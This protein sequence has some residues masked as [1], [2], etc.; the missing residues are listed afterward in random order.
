MIYHVV[1]VGGAAH[2]ARHFTNEANPT[3]Q[4]QY[5]EGSSPALGISGPIFLSAA[6]HFGPDVSSLTITCITSF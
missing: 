4:L 3:P 2:F 1:F 6:C 5:P